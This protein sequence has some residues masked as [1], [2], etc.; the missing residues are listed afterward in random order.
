MIIMKYIKELEKEHQICWITN[1]I[2]IFKI[3]LG[4]IFYNNYYRIYITLLP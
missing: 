3:C 4:F 1:W 2:L